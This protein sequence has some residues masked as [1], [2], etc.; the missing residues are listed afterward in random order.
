MTLYAVDYLLYMSIPKESSSGLFTLDID[1]MT[2]ASCVGRVEKALTKI[3]GVEAASVNLATEQA[4]VRLNASSLSKIDDV[5]AAVKKTGYDAHLS[6]PHQSAQPNSSQSFWGTDGLGRVLLS[7]ILSA[8]LFL[9]MLLMPL[10]I[11]WTLSPIWQ[12]LLASPVQFFLGWRFYKSGFKALLSGVGNMDLLVALGTSAAFGLSVYEMIA[13]PHASHELYFEGSAVII[14]MV[15][16]GKWLEARAKK[17]TSEAIRALQKLWPEHAKVLDTNIVIEDGV[18]LDQYRDLPLE[19]V[20]PGDRI[21]V[22]PGERIPVDGLILLG[23]SHIDESLLT[24]ESAPLKKSINAKVIGGSLNG[25][26]VL[27]IETKAVGVE[28]VLSKIISLVEDTQTQKAPIQKLVDQVS[29]IFVPSVIVIAIITGIANWLYLD[30]AA[31]GI[32]RAVSVLVIACPCALGLATP[33]AIMAGTGI[34]ARFGILIKDPQV[35]ELAHRLNIVAFDKT[36]TLTLGKPSLLELIPFEQSGP[37]SDQDAILASAAGLQLGSEHPL[38]KALLEAAKQKAISPISPTDS[39][40]TPGV[41]ISGKPSS[42]PW[43]GQNLA[44]QSLASLEQN[45]HYKLILEKVQPCFQNGQTVSILMNEITSSPLAILGFGDEL[46]INAQAAIASL[47]KM[48]IHTVMLSGDNTA[49]ATRVAQ[50]IG[51]DEVYGQILPSNKADIIRKLQSSA[52]DRK[53]QWVAMVGDGI[54]DA[55]ALVAADVGMAMSTG[56]DVAMQAA[57]ITLM[58]GDPSLVADAIDISKRTWKKIQQNLFWAFVFNST[59]IPLAAFGYLSPMLA[60]SAM[61]LSSFCVLSNALLLKRWRPS[62][63]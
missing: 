36:G 9:P 48:H 35:L 40:A 43:V 38:A 15:L 24:G 10:G 25:E 5:I 50:S 26:G 21:L 22:L 39:K 62:Q 63:R 11:H 45:P 52:L 32:L 3:P 30:S 12:L 47:K 2:C 53:R 34:A 20:F 51:I 8:P 4:R 31:I 49:A 23:S 19:H 58:R 41:G 54:N 55:P 44:L 16:L 28:S 57:G 60:G 61:A 7:F 13:N 17:Q 1:G 46:K 59:G 42:G 33:A 29:A 56:T 27:V 37:A 18:A 6:S 14:C